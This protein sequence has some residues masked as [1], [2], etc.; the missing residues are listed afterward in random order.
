MSNQL[1]N[2]YDTSKIFVW[3]NRYQAEKLTNSSYDDGTLEAGTVMARFNGTTTVVPFASVDPKAVD[4]IG[5]L[6][7]DTYIKA[8][9]TVDVNICVAGDVVADKLKFVGGDTLTTVIPTNG[10]MVLDV[11]QGETVGIKV[12]PS[13]ELTEFD[14]Q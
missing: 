1:F 12:V 7:Q 14:N 11:L 10:F 3:D 9:D 8:G 13:T 2:N 5:V 4:I 6:S